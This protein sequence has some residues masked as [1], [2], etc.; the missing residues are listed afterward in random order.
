MNR[1]KVAVVHPRLGA[2]GSEARAL[3]ALQA[4]RTE[5]EMSL[6]TCGPVDLERL[7]ALYGTALAPQDFR[8]RRVPL[9][10]GINGHRFTALQGHILQ[11]YCQRAAAE[12]D[13][14]ISTYNPMSFGVPAIQCIAD[15]S[16]VPEL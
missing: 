16:F 13:A 2:G 10:P 11:R 9:P 14:M 3:W 8:H 1:L 4:L 6:I 5:F 7:N 15:F 12:F